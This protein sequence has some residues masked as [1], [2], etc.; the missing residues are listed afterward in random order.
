[1][2]F[3]EIWE[4]LTFATGLFVLGLIVVALVVL[5]GGGI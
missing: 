3:D 5:V 2:N 4:T 1:M